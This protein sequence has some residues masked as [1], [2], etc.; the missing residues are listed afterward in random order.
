MSMN[1]TNQAFNQVFKHA[2]DIEFLRGDQYFSAQNGLNETL[3]NFMRTQDL[4]ELSA[5]NLRRLTALVSRHRP[6][7][8]HMF[9]IKISEGI[10]L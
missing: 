8:P 10:E 5:L 7:Q 6:I 4:K 2:K 1:A 9:L 3:K